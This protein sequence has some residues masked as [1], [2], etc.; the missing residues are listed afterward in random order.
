MGFVSDEETAF[1][2][3][4]PLIPLRDIVVFP[5]MIVPI[6]ISE[7][8][9]IKAVDAALD[10]DKKIFL[11]AFDFSVASAEESSSLDVHRV[12]TFAMIMRVRK[13]PDGRVKVLVQ[14]VC[15]ASIENIVENSDYPLVQISELKDS[16]LTEEKVN[17][18]ARIRTVRECLEKVI[19]MG[20]ALSPDILMILEDI[21]EPGRLS[22]LI[23]SNLG[24]SVAD[25]Q[26]VLNIT[27]PVQRL[28]KVHSLLLREL[29]LF[30]MQAKIQSQAKEEFDKIQREHYLR[31][32][33]KALR[34]ELGDSSDPK[35]EIE[36][37]WGK[38]DKVA[39]TEEAQIEITR[40]IKRLERIVP[41]SGE[42]A[43]TRNYI[44][45]VLALPWQTYSND[46]MNL[47]TVE[48]IL[49]EDHYGLQ[50]VKDRI[51]EY[52]AVKR[53]NPDAKSP[54]MCFVG[55]PGVGKTSLGRSIA[56]AMGRDFSRISLGGVKDEADIRGHRKTYIGAYPG[57]LIQAIKKTKTAN[58][59]IMLD[60]IDKLA[61]DQRGDP[62]SAL[63]EVLDPEQNN[64]FVD[65][66]LSVAFDLSKVLFI[67]NA[68]NLQSIPHPLR[69]RLEII[70]IPGYSEEEKVKIA[71]KFLL[72]K[73]LTENGLDKTMLNLK[74]ESLLTLIREYTRESGLRELERQVGS[75]CRKV[76][77][78]VAETK[79]TEKAEQRNIT[80]DLVRKFLGIPKYDG[81]VYLR[82][83]AIGVSLA[84]AYTPY[85]GEIFTYRNITC[86]RQIWSCCYRPNRLCDEGVSTSCFKLYQG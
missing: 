18:E 21:D 35:D 27:D 71:E 73:Q 29:D 39:L 32:Q 42:A 41:D 6:F 59:V 72:P 49:D 43:L 52:L 9:C 75:V 56:T 12:G 8:E 68:N 58:P 34:T 24:L 63:L 51:I 67:A 28:Q 13:L 50:K 64:T 78:K 46:R 5:H 17:V 62:S 16:E 85:G 20:K 33:I 81:S 36:E 25:A 11:S 79:E 22:D 31:E 26:E 48:S 55:A 61:S 1:N 82:P 84:M 40:Q 54:I 83:Q 80:P 57:R 14:G 23:A 2:S 86:L 53:L 37:L 38:M 3:Q 44:E 76:A 45:T 10:N 15:K 4:V 69:D 66:Y 65:H 74:D 60:E 19:Q 47:Q 70:E 77:R 30:E 7:D